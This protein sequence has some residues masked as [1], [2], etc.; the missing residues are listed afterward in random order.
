MNQ[1]APELS[2]KRPG[3]V[4]EGKPVQGEDGKW[5]DRFGEKLLEDQSKDSDWTAKFWSHQPRGMEDT[6]KENLEKALEQGSIT[7]L[8]G[9]GKEL[10]DFAKEKMSAYRQLARELG[11]E[12]GQFKLHKNSGTATM[13]IGKK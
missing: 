3:G 12:V 13:E 6:M 10:D 7:V 4:L 8:I 5:H 9:G 1:E 2:P 11:Y